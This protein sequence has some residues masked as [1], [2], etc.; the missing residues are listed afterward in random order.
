[1]SSISILL[2]LGAW[3]VWARQIHGILLRAAIKRCCQRQMRRQ[4][5]MFSRHRFPG[6]YRVTLSHPLPLWTPFSI[7]VLSWYCTRSIRGSISSV[8]SS[9]GMKPFSYG[10]S[11][12]YPFASWI[13]AAMCIGR[14][15]RQIVLPGISKSSSFRF[16]CLQPI[17]RL[18]VSKSM[19]EKQIVGLVVLRLSHISE[20][21]RYKKTN[22]PEQLHMLTVERRLVIQ[23]E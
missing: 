7:C 10:Y 8:W 6:S 16:P 5:A 19:T 14:G 22:G 17:Y 3:S 11:C 15:L 13:L 4:V 1:M 23:I 2:L 21:L 18:R 12:P 9:L 20:R